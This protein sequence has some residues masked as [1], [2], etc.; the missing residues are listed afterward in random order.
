MQVSI[1]SNSL[2]VIIDTKGGE[3]IS[4][5]DTDDIEYI[6]HA[7]PKY[8]GQHG[9]NIFPYI[10][11]LTNET[12][13]YRDE[14]YHMKIHGIIPY[15]DL[16]LVYKSNNKITLE[17]ES[18]SYSMVEYPFEFVYYITYILNGRR[19]EISYNVF[20]RDEKTMY[21]GIGGHPGFNVPLLG[22]NKF[23]DYY[24]E[25]EEKCNPTR[26][27]FTKQCYLNGN[28]TPFDLER[29]K[30]IRLS[31]DLFDDDAIVLKDVSRS[32]YLKSIKDNRSINIGFEDMGYLGLWHKPKSDAPYICIEPWSS[33]PSREN[34]IEDIERQKDLI[35]LAPKCNYNTGWYI[36]IDF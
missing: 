18:S 22:D 19:L 31:H 3:I 11:R 4:I 17:F 21:F 29:Q 12:Y 23:E 30:I 5:K 16:K 20:N 14:K 13:Y 9:L 34:I 6:W 2:K 8:W 10:A 28:D 1:N 33:L 24:I 35:S 32:V 15:S 26:I 27:G 7:D 25:F 36:E